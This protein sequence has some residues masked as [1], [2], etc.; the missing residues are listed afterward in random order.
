ML[1]LDKTYIYFS[2]NEQQFVSTDKLQ[3]V[4][5]ADFSFANYEAEIFIVGESHLMQIKDL[6]YQEAILH[7]KF[8]NAVVAFNIKDSQSCIYENKINFNQMA[9]LSVSIEIIDFDQDLIHSYINNSFISHKFADSAVTAAVLSSD[10]NILKTLHSYHEFGKIILSET[11][12][13]NL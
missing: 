3:I 10:G 7:E 6:P 4:S 11:K 1:N 9:E 8:N 2:T 13:T 5:Y 12:Y